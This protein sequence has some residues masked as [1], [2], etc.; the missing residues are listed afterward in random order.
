MTKQTK[1]A[2][3]VVV[4]LVCACMSHEIRGTPTCDGC[5]SSYEL[6][7]KLGVLSCR[8]SLVCLFVALEV[9][10]PYVFAKGCQNSNDETNK[11]GVFSRGMLFLLGSLEVK[12]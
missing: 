11:I 4:M 2:S 8:L 12:C 1:L 5:H 9:L 6:T 7:N 10:V 3:S